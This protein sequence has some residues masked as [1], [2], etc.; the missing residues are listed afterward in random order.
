MSSPLCIAADYTLSPHPPFR[1]DSHKEM[2][3]V[4]LS[5]HQNKKMPQPICNGPDTYLLRV[6]SGGERRDCRRR[7][8]RLFVYLLISSPSLFS[9]G[10]NPCQVYL[11]SSAW[12]SW[13]LQ[14]ARSSR[15][16]AQ[17]SPYHRCVLLPSAPR[18]T[19]GLVL[20][21]EMWSWGGHGKN[22]YWRKYVLVKV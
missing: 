8:G 12:G 14:L 3:M 22:T 6:Q 13:E 5:Q 1:Q 9:P 11:Q 7:K 17:R 21:E 19:F 4:Y 15:S 20:G 2:Q 16:G 18:W 10:K